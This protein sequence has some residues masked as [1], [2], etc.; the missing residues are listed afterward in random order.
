[1]ADEDDISHTQIDIQ[2][3]GRGFSSLPPCADGGRARLRRYPLQVG[4]HPLFCLL[5]PHG[6]ADSWQALS[7][8]E[9]GSSPF[10]CRRSKTRVREKKQKIKIKRMAKKLQGTRGV[11]PQTI[12][13]T[14]KLS[15]SQPFCPTGFSPQLYPSPVPTVHLNRPLLVYNFLSSLMEL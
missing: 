4:Q 10:V 5:L 15:S 7:G 8:D 12:D 9:R 13:Q 3:P 2:L 14:K 1:M 6:E 11:P